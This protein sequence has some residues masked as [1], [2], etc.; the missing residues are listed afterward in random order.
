MNRLIHDLLDIS[1]L[2]AGRLELERQPLGVPALLQEALESMAELA[3][4]K[5]ATVERELAPAD[6]ALEVD[7]DRDRLLQVFSNLIGN[8]IKFG[9]PGGRVV[10]RAQRRPGAIEF[11]V[12]DGGPGI[13][14]EHLPHL[15]DRFWRVRGRQRDGTGLGLWIVKGLV[16]AHGGRVSVATELGK[17]STFSFTLPL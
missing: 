15:F 4:E 6:E 3:Q 9:E 7:G 12:A 8:A 11:S 1:A 10:V 17:G 16:E 5:P 13:A 2:D 14:P